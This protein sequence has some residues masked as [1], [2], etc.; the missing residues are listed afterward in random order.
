MDGALIMQLCA[1]WILGPTRERMSLLSNPVE[2]FLFHFV[3]WNLNN[4]PLLPL[5]LL[6]PKL[7]I[8]VN[9]LH[10]QLIMS[11]LYEGCELVSFGVSRQ[12]SSAQS[13][14]STWPLKWLPVA[15]KKKLMGT[16]VI[17]PALSLSTSHLIPSAPAK[18]LWLLSYL[19]VQILP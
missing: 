16:Q 8:C 7:A 2:K 11:I 3:I 1:R 14:S 15:F 19:F 5:C 9:S 4:S 18:L 17:S 13:S 6:S 12:P 10:N